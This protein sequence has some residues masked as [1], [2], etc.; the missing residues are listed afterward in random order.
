[1]TMEWIL[2]RKEVTVSDHCFRAT[3]P[4]RYLLYAL[5]CVLLAN[6][7]KPKSDGKVPLPRYS[8][9]EEEIAAARAKVR[10][11]GVNEVIFAVR[12]PGK[13]NHWYANFSYRSY[14]PRG[15][16]YGDGGRLA[17]LDLASGAVRVLLDDPKGG[18]RD[19]QVHYDG[20]KIIFSYR[21]GGQPFY[22]LYE[23]QADGSGLKQLT[24]G[25]YDDIE[26][27]YLP[28]GGIVFCS[29]RCNRMVNCWTTRVA[30]IYR[31]D[32]DGSNVRALSANIEHDNTPWVLPD[33]R[34]LYMRWEYVDRLHTAYHH[35]WTMNP[36]GTEQMVYFGNLHGGTVMLDAKP[37]P[38][39]R[40]VVASFSPGHG[41]REHAGH[42]TIV[43]PSNGPDDQTRARR[44]SSEDDREAHWRDPY[45]LSES[46]F[47]VAGPETDLRV[48][49]GEGQTM[50]LYDLPQ[51]DK[52][53]GLWIHEPRPLVPRPRE[54]V[55]ATT[56]NL[57]RP[58]GRVYLQDAYTGRNMKGIQR[59]EIKKLLV[60]ETLPK[61]VNFSGKQVPLSIGGTFTLE[62]IL[63][64]VPV[65]EDGSAYFEVPALRSVFFVALDE[66]DL[67]VKRMHSFMTV[68]PGESVSC[69]GCHEHR[70]QTLGAARPGLAMGR[71]P[72]RIE[73]IAGVPDVFDFPRD[74][75]PIL[76]RHCVACHDY[77]KTPSGGPRAGGVILA[78]DRGPT[79]SHAYVTLT[80]RGL[81]SDG[82]NGSGNRPPRT[83]GSSA[84]R[85]LRLADGTH[86]GAKPSAAETAMLRLWIESGAAYPGTY[87]A[88]GSGMVGVSV[89]PAAWTRRGTRYLPSGPLYKGM[90]V[91]PAPWTRRCA[92]CHTAAEEHIDR[93]LAFSLTRP[94]QSLALLAP[95]APAAG[96]YGLCRRLDADGKPT[97]QPAAV[98]AN[99]ADEDY[100]AILKGIADAKTRL[101]LVKRFDMPGF[102][103]NEHYLREM[104]VYGILPADWKDG[105]PIDPYQVDRLYWQSQWY[106]P[107]GQAGADQAAAR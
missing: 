53:K 47:L 18:V 37:I 98:F 100:Q 59:G 80:R 2:K 107:P 46:C 28:D 26:P 81:F 3:N 49:N 83:I 31:C 40:N 72:S 38:G 106:V 16:L 99:T 23:I 12:Q 20:R 76:D 79:Y 97:G 95:L 39:T 93:E 92:E 42:V 54:S 51:A 65:E 21:S 77:A 68:Q 44:V 34:V 50:V 69:V 36:D 88:L 11:F 64:T 24:D 63:G 52:A 1:M 101:D 66:N 60:L 32:G 22:H 13:D 94:E 104:K 19:P 25:P 17:A 35:L 56:T 103:P 45:P 90:S 87:A 84:S 6:A 5:L 78:G 30:V 82:H 96:G 75:Q 33:G 62:R 55:L 4:K 15:R 14:S 8:Q 29:S 10:S 70:V 61:P 86:Y 73:P 43:D 7:G 57:A 41:R 102:R 71:K 58:T 9:A 85:L 89:E 74:I 67:S 48:M 91:E 27:A 105:D